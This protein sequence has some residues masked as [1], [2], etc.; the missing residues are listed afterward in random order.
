MQIEPLTGGLLNEVYRMRSPAGSIVVKRAGAVVRAAPDVTLSQDRLRFEALALQ[1]FDGGKLATLATEAIRPP[2]LLKAKL[3]THMLML[4]DLGDVTPARDRESAQYLGAF[5]SALHRVSEGDLE[6]AETFVNIDVQ[7]V[8]KAIQY[9]ELGTLL[10]GRAHARAADFDAK[11]RALGKAFMQPGTCLTHG[12]LWPASVLATSHGVRVID[13]EFCHY[14][15]PA[16]DIGHWLAHCWL[17]KAAA[18]RDGFLETYGSI[19]DA[20]KAQACVHA[21]CEILMR[22]I[23]RFAAQSLYAKTDDAVDFAVRLAL[24]EEWH[25]L[26]VGQNA[27]IS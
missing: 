19:D 18:L 21:G 25:Q 20:V 3:E 2:R 24:G 9:D 1:L 23:G 6:L 10:A 27:G 8:R 26:V 11:A 13:W 4:E 17:A 7:R 5:I 16:Q 14:G 15:H 12:D 22:T